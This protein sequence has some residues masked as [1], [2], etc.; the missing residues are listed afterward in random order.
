MHKVVLLTGAPGS[1]K[2]TLRRGLTQ[3]IP[4]LQGFD[5]GELLLRRKTHQG[6]N[7]R[8]EE[9]REQSAAVIS[10]SDVAATDDWVVSEIGR[11]R[12]SSHVIIDSHALTREAYGFRAIPFCLVHLRDLKLNGVVVLRCDPETL[13]KRVQADPRGR[14]DLSVELAREIQ[15]LQESLSIMYAVACACPFYAIDA[16]QL[17]ADQ[18]LM[19]SLEILTK[20]GIT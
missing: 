9:L 13:I 10:P 2:T 1:G 18:V 14:R 7:L 15:L 5:Y 19:V 20:L 12:S 4:N 3:Q 8:Y 16:T 17:T 6:L 11:L